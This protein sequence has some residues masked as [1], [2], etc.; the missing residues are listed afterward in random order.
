ML[1]GAGARQCHGALWALDVRTGKIV[2][3]AQYAIPNES[4]ML[5]TD[6]NLVF[7]GHHTGRL[8]AYDADSLNELWSFSLGTPITAPPMTYSVGGKQYIA[9]VAGGDANL[10]GAVLYQPS[11]FVAVFGR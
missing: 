8:V 11:A 1:P 9:V 3:K 5:G 4:G 10:R 7:T 6:G 2:A